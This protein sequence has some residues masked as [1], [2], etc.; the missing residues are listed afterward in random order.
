[1]DMLLDMFGYRETTITP[2]TQRSILPATPVSQSPI[3]P[4]SVM[5][6]SRDPITPV[7]QRPIV[8]VSQRPIVP[9]SHDPVTSVSQGPVVPVSHDPVTPVSQGP[10]V[11][12][13]HDPVTPVSQGP[14]VP[15]SQR[16]IVPVSQSH[17][18][19]ATPMSQS[20]DTP[21]TPQPR[22][23]VTP[24]TPVC[25]MNFV[26]SPMQ[27]SQT[28]VMSAKNPI[29]AVQATPPLYI[30]S[31]DDYDSLEHD[32]G[33]ESAQDMPPEY[34]QSRSSYEKQIVQEQAWSFPSNGEYQ[35]RQTLRNGKEQQ[36]V[37]TECQQGALDGQ[38]QQSKQQQVINLSQPSGHV[39]PPP[40]V[41]KTISNQPYVV[42]SH[43]RPPR[44]IK[45][46]NA[47]LPSSFIKPWGDQKTIHEVIEA[48]H[49]LSKVSKVSTL[50]VKIARDAVFGEAVMRKCTAMGNREL[51][52]LPRK[53]LFEVKTALFDLFPSYWR[54]SEEFET[55]WATCIESIGQACKR[56]R[57]KKP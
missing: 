56:L 51:P 13:S 47:A 3:T 17:V 6:V 18:T 31:E 54:S 46:S 34:W 12:V 36:G 33:W 39:Q 14:V 19:P 11:P 8:P 57:L 7:S 49:K 53:E 21:A 48:N 4:V 5:P 27:V 23:C 40:Q 24:A 55:V 26:T 37:W 32:W 52:G 25:P 15:V 16:P 35:N 38:Q 28:P 43:H 20:H 44:P 22:S 29:T 2:V 1:M 42:P 9:V 10:V 45:E 41:L 50:A 30:D